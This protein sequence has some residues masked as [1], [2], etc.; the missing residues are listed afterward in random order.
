MDLTIYPS[1]YLSIYPSIHLSIFLAITTPVS[2]DLIVVV[3]RLLV[4]SNVKL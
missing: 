1:I 2:P 3:Q 4:E